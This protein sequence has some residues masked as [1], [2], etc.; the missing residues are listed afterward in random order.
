MTAT[1]GG[2]TVKIYKQEI[3]PPRVVMTTKP[4]QWPGPKGLSDT[5]A[6]AA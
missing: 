6:K 4:G 3:Q 5:P 2:P 1:K